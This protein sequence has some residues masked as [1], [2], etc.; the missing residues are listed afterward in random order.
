MPEENK[1]MRLTLLVAIAILALLPSAQALSEFHHLD[2]SIDEGGRSLVQNL[3]LINS[4]SRETFLVPVFTPVQIQAY[5]SRGDLSH[6]LTGDFIETT[7]RGQQES[8]S[9][10]AEYQTDSLT[11]KEGGTWAFQYQ[12]SPLGDYRSGLTLSLPSNA[13]LLSH[14]PQGQVYTHQGR[15][16]IDFSLPEEPETI[17]VSYTI[18]AAPAPQP[19]FP[20]F[21]ATVAVII[22]I[23]V[24]IVAFHLLRRKKPKK[25]ES[26]KAPAEGVSQGKK[27]LL[28]TLSVN[29]KKIVDTLL[30]KEKLTQKQ[31]MLATGIPKAT[32]SRTLKSLQRKQFIELR[33]FGNTNQIALS[34]WF[35]GK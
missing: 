9:F 32:L 29:E 6:K 34:D 20:L 27:D 3:L 26:Q 4:T 19:Q 16:K 15:I 13:R 30:S 5:D 2:I 8:Y 28:K 10:T 35:L 24:A 12:F 17:Q 22:I 21:Q 31:L 25:K 33:A 14:S 11:S 23:V 7:L 18:E 1:A